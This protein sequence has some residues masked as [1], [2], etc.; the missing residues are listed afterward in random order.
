MKGQYAALFLCTGNSARSIM[1]ESILNQLGAGRFQAFSAGSK[2]VG[3]VNPYALELLQSKGYD[4]AFARSKSWNE[5]E[6]PSAP[7]LDFVFTVCGNAANEECPYW[8]GTPAGAHW[9]IFDPADASGSPADIRAA[10]ELAYDMLETRIRRFV[11]LPISSMSP[12]AV[13][14]ALH[15]IGDTDAESR[16]PS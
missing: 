12:D 3:R 1:S 10:F 6:G 5:F 7:K 14:A 2:P 9:G 4:I 13:Q 16:V 15:A 11:D 8:P